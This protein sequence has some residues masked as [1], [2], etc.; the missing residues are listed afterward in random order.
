[1]SQWFL[2][3]KN[4]FNMFIHVTFLRKFVIASLIFEW[5]YKSYK[6]NVFHQCG[7][8]HVFLKHNLKGSFGFNHF[9]QWFPDSSDWNQKID[10]IEMNRIDDNFFDSFDRN[11]LDSSDRNQIN[12]LFELNLFLWGLLASIIT[13]TILNVRMPV[14]WATFDTCHC[15]WIPIIWDIFC[16]WHLLLSFHI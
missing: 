5:F 14:F 12:D 16:F 9:N 1:M 4:W 7:S 13:T 11:Q 6:H 10:F 8:V 2:S 3:F 15:H